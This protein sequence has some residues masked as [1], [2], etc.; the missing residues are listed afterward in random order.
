[1]HLSR[2]NG[3]DRAADIAID[4]A[5]NVYVTGSTNSTNF[6]VFDALID[7][8][9]GTAPDVF[10]CKIKATT[11]TLRFST[12]FG[13]AAP[14][15]RPGL[16]WMLNRQSV[17][18][19]NRLAGPASLAAA[20]GHAARGIDIFCVGLTRRDRSRS[21]RAITVAQV[22]ICPG[23]GVDRGR[24]SDFRRKNLLG[25]FPLLAPLYGACS[26]CPNQSQ[27]FVVAVGK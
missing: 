19:H 5:G 14:M 21:G 16:P 6:P 13:G 1:L 4:S 7:T 22:T 15:L 26:Q 23:H 12:Y 20:F 17:L 27:G 24:Q 8:L 3:N 2:R 18:W 25:E 11:K 10:V 9:A